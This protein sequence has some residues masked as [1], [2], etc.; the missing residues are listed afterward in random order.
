MYFLSFIEVTALRNSQSCIKRW[1]REPSSQKDFTIFKFSQKLFA[2]AD[3][4]NDLKC[5]KKRKF[6]NYSI[7][8]KIYIY[9]FL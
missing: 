6:N 9:I 1:N 8:M 5:K 7:I 4:E 3:V 2:K